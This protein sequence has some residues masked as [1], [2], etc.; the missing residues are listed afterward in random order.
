MS[1]LLHVSASPRDTSSD[2]RA[3]AGVFL[4]TH[5]R[6]HPDVVVDELDL[7]DGKLPAFGRLAAEAKLAVF[8]AATGARDPEHIDP[9]Q[10]LADQAVL[11]L[12]DRAEYMKAPLWDY[13]NNPGRYPDW[14]AWLRR[15]TSPW[16]RKQT[17]S[18]SSPMTSSTT[19]STT[20]D[21]QTARP[22]A[23]AGGGTKME[24]RHA[25]E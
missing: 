10:A 5:R 17:E 15:R 8:G 20:D 21:Q 25:V 11:D 2:S 24:K 9:E 7:F 14:Q 4:D 22:A 23:R 6:A 19:P 13:Q 18:P 3:L 1:T 12:P 16:K